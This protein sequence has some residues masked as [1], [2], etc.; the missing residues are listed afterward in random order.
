MSNRREFLRNALIGGAGIG[1]ASLISSISTQANALL[2]SPTFDE[3]AWT[4]VGAILRRIKAPVFPTRD[5]AITK[6]GAVGNGQADC[7][8]A[9]ARAINACTRAGGGRVQALIA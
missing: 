3:T 8:E 5:F 4:E 9:F 1:A 2:F 6:F 7:T